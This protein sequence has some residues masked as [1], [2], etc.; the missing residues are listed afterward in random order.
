[1]KK[2]F[3][4]LIFILTLNAC[5]FK[6]V[7]QSELVNFKISEITTSGDKK[8]NYVIKN[9]LN[10]YSKDNLNNIIT[11]ELKTE[12]EKNI[13]NEVT[14]YN[15]R[16]NIDVE[17]IELR[18][19]KKHRFKLSKSGEYSVASQYSQTLN[20]EKKLIKVYSDVLANE[21]LE[22]IIRRLNAV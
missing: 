17:I 14:K 5:G 20:K 10:P 3:L 19:N 8:I 7:D 4:T 16:I 2:K 21:L 12:K 9:K 1:M 6:V 22:E 18:N 13:N 15:I 11:I